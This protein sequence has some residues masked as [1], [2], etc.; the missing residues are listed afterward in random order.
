MAK[1]KVFLTVG[2]VLGFVLM[3]LLMVFIIVSGVGAPPEPET[4]APT[5]TEPMET[6]A[7]EIV[8]PPP[9][10]SLFTAQDFGYEGDY[11]TCL[12]VPCVRGIDVSSYQKEVDWEQVYAA[13]F[14]F[15]FIRV[16]GRGYGESGVLY[17][18]KRAQEHYEGAKAAGLKVGCY[19]FSQALNP[20]EAVEEAEYALELIEDWQ[21]DLPLVF[22]WECLA[23]NYRTVNTT[24]RE[25]TDCAK[26]FCQR[27]Q[28]AGIQPMVYFN[29]N[30]SFKSMYLEELT[31][32]PF[33]LAMYSGVMNYPFKVDF[34]QYTNKGSVPGIPGNADINLMFLYE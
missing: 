2:T 25:L 33:W 23:E 14:E 12:T 32:Y 30:Q 24:A 26:A 8:Q 34:W 27:V 21:L 13:G 29:T 7:G 22:D 18:D 31:D 5:T 10:L 3:A 4:T 11:L 9:E 28:E 19:F 6:V 15:V 17:W 16:A 20:E 1:T